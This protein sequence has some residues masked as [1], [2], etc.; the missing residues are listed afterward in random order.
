MTESWKRA[1]LSLSF[2]IVAHILIYFLI[3]L[4]VFFWGSGKWKFV[5]LSNH[6]FQA[7]QYYKHWI[8]LSHHCSIIFRRYFSDVLVKLSMFLSRVKIMYFCTFFLVIPKSKA[9]KSLNFTF[10]Q[11]QMFLLYSN[12]LEV[13]KFYFFPAE[14]PWKRVKNN[15]SIT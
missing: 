8:N 1:R 14:T 4:I 6:N 15:F 13:K 3:R 2:R 9:L 11:S 10:W 5:Y 7:F 12:E